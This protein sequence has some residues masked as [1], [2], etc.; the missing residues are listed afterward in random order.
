MVVKRGALEPAYERSALVIQAPDDRD[1]GDAVIPDVARLLAAVL[2]KNPP[3]QE[4]AL[5]QHELL[6]KRLDGHIIRRPHVLDGRAVMQPE[7]ECVIR[8]HG[9]VRLSRL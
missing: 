3:H 4:I 6:E 5:S 2:H 8:R 9:T 1:R 7:L